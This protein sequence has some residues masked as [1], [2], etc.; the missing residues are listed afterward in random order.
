MV[1]DRRLIR[2]TPL[3]LEMSVKATTIRDARIML[4]EARPNGYTQ[5]M[6]VSYH[7]GFG[8]GE[9]DMI[10]WSEEEQI[11]IVTKLENDGW[12]WVGT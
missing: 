12:K 7:C 5:N 9:I 2:W 1:A 8:I 4:N 3:K 6:M 11:E 10:N